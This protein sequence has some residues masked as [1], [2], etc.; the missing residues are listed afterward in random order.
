MWGGG[1]GVCLTRAHV[2]EWVVDQDQLVKVEL[3]G[4]PFPFGLVKDP[5][6]VVVSVGQTKGERQGYTLRTQDRIGKPNPNQPFNRGFFPGS[7]KRSK[8]CCV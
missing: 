4:E 6:I 5:L 3:V 7:K 2:Y 8:R 1:G